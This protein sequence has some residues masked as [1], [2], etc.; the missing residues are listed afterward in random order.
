MVSN[1]R[2][3][4][5]KLQPKGTPMIFIG[6]SMNH[7]SGTYEFYNPVNDSIVISN[8]VKWSNFIRWDARSNDTPTGNLFVN[9]EN[10]TSLS[11]NEDDLAFERTDNSASQQ[12]ICMSKDSVL[13]DLLDSDNVTDL[14]DIPEPTGVLT[15]SKARELGDDAT[16]KIPAST[17]NRELKNLQS[18]TTYKVTGNTVPT[19]VFDDSSSPSINV[20]F[21]DDIHFQFSS[22]GGMSDE[23]SSS[24]YLS[25]M[26]IMHSCIQSDPGEPTRWKDALFGPER[27]YWIQ[28]TTAEFNNFISRDAWKFVNRQEVYDK[29]RKVIPTK[30]VFKKKN[31][32]DGSI[33]FK[34][35]D[36]TLGYMMIP[37]V[38]YTERFSPVAMDAS[39]RIQICLTLAYYSQ[40]WRTMS[41]DIEAAFLEADMNTEM[42]IEPHPAM[43]VCGFMTEEQR[44]STAIRLMKSMYGNV[45]AAIK[46]FKTL[47]SH[48]TDKNGMDMKQSQADPCVFYKFDNKNNLIIMVSVT[49]DDC[50][51]TGTT[52]NIKWFMDGL[53]TR[54]KI[55]R[56]GELK[57]HLGVEYTWGRT[58]DGK[59]YCDATMVKKANA[60]V[61]HYEK[62]T[63]KKVKE[64]E[65]PGI[66]NEHLLKNEG[67]TLDLDDF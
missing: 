59:M 5:T 63:N 34:T 37:G 12:K 15:R 22:V 25:N 56:D 20:I 35:R 21:T 67:P 55:T 11:D 2:T 49:V 16:Y 44:Q 66:P 30:L 14:P 47:T 36:V 43:V 41:C 24:E 50:A 65:T 39:L 10:N 38:D 8:S 13:A 26:L 51:I 64:S 4:V 61:A 1:K 27:E 46:F 23:T 45:D 32:I 17:T 40:G 52:E 42:Y 29:N 7:P 54:F 60:I 53:E 28:A 3:H 6:Y 19:K 9:K 31:E 48:V 18:S 62:H 33:R 57:K 58:D